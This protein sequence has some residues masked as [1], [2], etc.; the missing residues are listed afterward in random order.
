MATHPTEN[1]RGPRRAEEFKL[2][3]PRDLLDRVTA[4]AAARG[5][6]RTSFIIRALDHAAVP[7]PPPPA[8]SPPL[9]SAAE[10]AADPEPARREEEAALSA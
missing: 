6:S 2:R 4:A 10:P 7:P 5:C 8:P 1:R 9:V 3:M